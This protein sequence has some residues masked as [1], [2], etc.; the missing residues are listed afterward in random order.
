MRDQKILDALGL[1][2]VKR[3]LFAV[4]FRDDGVNV[5][6][7]FKAFE[8]AFDGFRRLDLVLR[9]FDR[10]AALPVGGDGRVTGDEREKQKREQFFHLR[11]SSSCES[12]RACF[13]SCVKSESPR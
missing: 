1:R 8:C 3:D 13:S 6:A 7:D 2:K 4:I 9:V 12:R 10:P 11:F 5:V